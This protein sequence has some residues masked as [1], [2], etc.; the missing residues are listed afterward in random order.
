MNENPPLPV[1][2]GEYWAW[3]RTKVC[4]KDARYDVHVGRVELSIDPSKPGALPKKIAFAFLPLIRVE[5]HTSFDDIGPKGWHSIGELIPEYV[6]EFEG[7]KFDKDAM[8]NGHAGT[9]VIRSSSGDQ[10]ILSH[11][12]EDEKLIRFLLGLPKLEQKAPTNGTT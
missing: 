1:A 4:A 8:K 11:R 12:E 9:I 10:I 5:Q 3:V 6:L 7:C 2:N